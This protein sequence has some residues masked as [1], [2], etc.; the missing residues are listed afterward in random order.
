MSHFGCF[1]RIFGRDKQ[2]FW[3]S[4]PQVFMQTL[5]HSDKVLQELP[6]FPGPIQPRP[7]RQNSPF[8][9]SLTDGHENIVHYSKRY[10]GTHA[11]RSHVH[12]IP[13]LGSLFT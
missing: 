13:K 10:Y 7:S 9:I 2:I 3:D 6:R 5:Y 11:M 12:E 1:T 8:G 4:R